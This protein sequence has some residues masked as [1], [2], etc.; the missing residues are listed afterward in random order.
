[1]VHLDNDRVAS[2]LRLRQRWF[3][4]TY[5]SGRSKKQAESRAVNEEAEELLAISS[6]S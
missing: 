3:L 4:P 6:W 5:T 2:R 1:V